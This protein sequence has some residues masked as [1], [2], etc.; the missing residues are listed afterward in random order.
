MS[1]LV[2][3]DPSN[4]HS[5]LLALLKSDGFFDAS[6]PFQIMNV[7]KLYYEACRTGNGHMLED[8]DR[9]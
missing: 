4:Q 5:A 2:N 9:C 6:F 7:H 1:D 8:N 3:S